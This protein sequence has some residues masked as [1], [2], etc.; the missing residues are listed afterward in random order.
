MGREINTKVR[1]D[2]LAGT[3]PLE[4][5]K[6]IVAMCAAGQSSKDPM[7]LA[8]ID[9]KRAYFYAPARREVFIEITDEDKEPG[10]EGKLG[11]LSLSLY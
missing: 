1:L 2:L 5:M 6:L 9:I 7:R 4:T 10:D 11:K 3:P 8:T